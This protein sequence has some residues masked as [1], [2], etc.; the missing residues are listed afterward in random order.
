MKK[1]YYIW[2]VADSWFILWFDASWP[3]FEQN[4]HKPNKLEWLTLKKPLLPSLILDGKCRILP[5]DH[6]PLGYAPVVVKTLD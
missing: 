4:P 3:R 1:F 2:L 6:T 5:T